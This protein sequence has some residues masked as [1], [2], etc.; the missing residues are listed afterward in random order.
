[1]DE[2]LAELRER[3]DEITAARR[4]ELIGTTLRVLVDAPGTARGHREAPEIDGVVQVPDSLAVGELHD[5]VVVD[6]L[7]PDLVAVEGPRVTVR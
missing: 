2:R 5:V 6:A 3:Q 4:D 7:G 1:M